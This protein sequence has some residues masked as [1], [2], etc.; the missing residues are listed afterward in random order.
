M[1]LVPHLSDPE[2]DNWKGDETLAC[3]THFMGDIWYSVNVELLN[4][5]WLNYI[6][7]SLLLF[8][9]HIYIYIFSN[10]VRFPAQSYTFGSNCAV[11]LSL[12]CSRSFWER[13][14]ERFWKEVFGLTFSNVSQLDQRLRE[15]LLVFTL[16]FMFCP[17]VINCPHYGAWH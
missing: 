2:R 14:K 5:Y 8:S 17:S 16:V 15:N 7:R 9:Q 4:I 6:S 11:T 12:K 10:S 1:T 13:D 3:K